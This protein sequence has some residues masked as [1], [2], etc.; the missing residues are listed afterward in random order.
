MFR[1]VLSLFRRSS[2]ACGIPARRIAAVIASP[3]ERDTGR[4]W[5]GPDYWRG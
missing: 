2:P 1:L 3:S 5:G 4:R